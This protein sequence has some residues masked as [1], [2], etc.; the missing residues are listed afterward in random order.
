MLRTVNASDRR[1]FYAFVDEFP[2][3]EPMLG[4][5]VAACLLK[6]ENPKEE[7]RL[8]SKLYSLMLTNG[9]G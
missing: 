3:Y 5:W 4:E 8:A 9:W 7:Y 6:G 1:Y 2:E